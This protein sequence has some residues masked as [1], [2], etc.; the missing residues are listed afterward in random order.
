M[1]WLSDTRQS[2]VVCWVS[3][4]HDT[5]EIILTNELTQ[6]MVPDNI[7]HTAYFLD[8]NSGKSEAA[9]TDQLASSSSCYIEVHSY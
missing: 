2:C 1:F 9:V 5:S 7:N 3:N 8:K 4:I 6:T